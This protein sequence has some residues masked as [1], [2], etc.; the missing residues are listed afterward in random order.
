M[1]TIDDPDLFPLDQS[2]RLRRSEKNVRSRSFKSRRPRRSRG[3][4]SQGAP[5]NG[6]HRRRR[7]VS[8]L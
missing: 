6:I 2:I 4:N 7:R 3:R 8:A 1:T 5:H